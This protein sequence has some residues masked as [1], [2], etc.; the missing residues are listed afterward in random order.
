MRWRQHMTIPVRQVARAIP[1]P[2]NPRHK[3][4]IVPESRCLGHGHLRANS[5]E[6]T[7]RSRSHDNIG[8]DHAMRRIRSCARRLIFREE[9]K[10]LVIL[11][12]AQQPE[13]TREA[14]RIESGLRT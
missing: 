11:G 10:A 3:D 2:T 7:H 1:P 14:V 12:A 13:Y 5:L 6:E 8:V 4:G 9:P